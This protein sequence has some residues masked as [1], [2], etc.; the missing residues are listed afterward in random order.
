MQAAKAELMRV[1][2]STRIVREQAR[3]DA[4][5]AVL[6]VSL[7]RRQLAIAAKADT[8]AQKR[9]EVAYNRY[10]IGRIDVDQLYLAQQAKDQALLSYVQSLRGYWQ[11][12][13]RLRRVTLYDFERGA[14]IR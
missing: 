13:Y 2:N 10:V 1:Q 11:A 7:A 6:Q 14:G 5:F 8:V 3:Q 12:H 9:F 4:H